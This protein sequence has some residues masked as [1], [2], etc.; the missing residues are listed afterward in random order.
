M[1]KD[2]KIEFGIAKSEVDNFIESLGDKVYKK[3]FY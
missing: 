1:I 2:N 3:Y